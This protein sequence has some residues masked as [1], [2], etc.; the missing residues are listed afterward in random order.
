MSSHVGARLGPYEILSAIGSGGMGDVYRARDSRLGRTVAIKVLPP[1]YAAD[2][3]RRARFEREARAISSLAH[4]HVCTLYDVGHDSGVDFI[5]ME[6]LDGESLAERLKRGPP[7]LDE[8]LQYAIQIAAALYEAHR[9]GVVHRDLKP[10]NVMITR[11]GAR[12]LDFGLAR[13]RPTDE[14]GSAPSPETQTVV[15]APHVV[16]GTVSYMA[17]EQL[18]GREADSR[19][20]IFSFGVLL[21]ELVTGR[22]PFDADT[23]AGIMAGIL[24]KDA[25]SLSVDSKSSVPAALE[26]LVRNC[27][28]KEPERRWQ[29]ARD[30]E[31][32]LSAIQERQSDIPAARQPAKLRTIAAVAAAAV[33]LG[34]GAVLGGLALRGW[35]GQG[36]S[37]GRSVQFHIPLAAGESIHEHNSSSVAFSADGTKIA[38]AVTR[39]DSRG[40]Y[41][42]SL[43]A[44]TAKWIPTGDRMASP[45]F[46]PDGQWIAFESGG[47]LKKVELDGG[48]PVL[49]CET[50]YF[51]GG[52]WAP[53]GTIV[54][55]PSFTGGLF[56][57]GA[58]GGVPE[59]L[60][61]PQVPERGHMWPQ[62]LPDGRILFTIW[63]GG[64]FDQAK[65]A[66][67]S[68]AS[69]THKIV[70]E[71]GFHGRY[72]NG[73]L[74]FGRGSKLLAIPF[75]LAA[76]TVT[77]TAESLVDGVAGDGGAGVA[78]FDIDAQGSLAYASGLQRPLPRT[79]VLVEPSGR[80]ASTQASGRA[81]NSARFSPD[82]QRLALWIEEANTAIWI[83]H[84]AREPLTRLT[85]SGDDHGPVWS[86][87]GQW[88]AFESGRE[89]T[90]QIFVRA[91]NGSGVDREITQGEFHHYLNDWSP[92]GRSL[93]YVEFHPTTG[94]DLWI[95]NVE[96]KS[97][98][99]PFRVTPFSERYAAF[100]SDGRW[101]AYVSNE[102]GRN[103][104]YV[105]AASGSPERTQITDGGGEEPAWSR[106]GDLL[107]YRAGGG[108]MSVPTGVKGASFDAGRPAP[109]FSGLYHYNLI[110]SRTYDVAADGR[111][112]LVTLPD[113][114]SAPREV[115]VLLNRLR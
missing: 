94:A 80:V 5:V 68:P 47:S 56:R 13:L 88:V 31:L 46:S 52:S 87:D 100:S 97:E 36:P 4:P 76:E 101:I 63:M 115:S 60:T 84:L 110:P 92:D 99:R 8:A 102:T 89:S 3:D 69:K 86:P 75:D 41:V 113:P 90:H 29:S 6:H 1:A 17:P 74:V 18:R 15:T 54:L 23:G 24:E 25:P 70:W 81:F 20:D 59:R 67:F 42:R 82:G 108:M 16:L 38:Y 21:F 73:R 26:R 107:Y 27:L 48:T 39:Q 78:M 106:R 14:P 9:L 64:S 43:D 72:S 91:A 103:E 62:V 96:G 65:L 109:L 71:G 111:F 93:V 53:D 35:R 28:I 112:V 105:Q 19:S 45:F 32:Q 98:P 49:L 7:P 2:P 79:M 114:A 58:A 34:A 30:L 40:G 77:G 104:V 83:K 51:A 61:Q 11:N 12:L 66:I 22:R 44:T 55:V 33:L 37:P 85:F 57:V 50:P 10:G 95:V